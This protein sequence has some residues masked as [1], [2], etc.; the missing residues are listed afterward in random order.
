MTHLLAYTRVIS[1]K[2]KSL[3]FFFLP[4]QPPWLQLQIIQLSYFTGILFS[5]TSIFDDLQEL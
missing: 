1:M 2:S 4:L 3:F 5:F